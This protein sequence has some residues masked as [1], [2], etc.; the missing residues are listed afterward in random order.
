MATINNPQEFLEKSKDILNDI[1]DTMNKLP[2]VKLEEFESEESVFILVDMING[3]A[4]E[5]ILKSERVEALIPEIL[6][7]SKLCDKNGIKKIAFA[8]NHTEDSI[9][10]EAYPRHC[11]I[12]TS[13]SELVEELKEADD[14][15]IIPKNSTNGFLEKA[16]QKWINENEKVTN[17]IVVGDCTDICIEQFSKSLKAYFN[18]NNRK[19]RVIVPLNA[20][21]TYDLG[22]HYAE[23]MDIMALYSMIVNGVEV[24][25]EIE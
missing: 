18:L 6:R 12:G 22:T 2:S 16:F 23:L 24:V 4:R 17:F 5:G 11:I 1:I 10:F 19:S 7:L 14:Y 25:K 3:F 13:E 15:L 8:D 9:E 20:V 21:D